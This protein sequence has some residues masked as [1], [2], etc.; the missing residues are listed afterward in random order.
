MHALD[1]LYSIHKHTIKTKNNCELTKSQVSY[2][3]YDLNHRRLKL[4][5]HIIVFLITY[6]LGCCSIF[7][8]V[9]SMS[10]ICASV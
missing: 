2:T 7:D 6:I 5:C 1:L 4:H 3:M 8:I 9:W 10:P